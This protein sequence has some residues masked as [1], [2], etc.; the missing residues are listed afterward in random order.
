M[1]ELNIISK[2]NLYKKLKSIGLNQGLINKTLPKWWENDVLKTNA[3]ILEFCLVVK[4][5]LGLDVDIAESGDISFIPKVKNIEF[6][7]RANVEFEKLAPSSFLAQ[8]I[9]S[10]LVNILKLN[11]VAPP[12]IAKL[13][14][15]IKQLEDLN[16]DAVIQLF[17]QFGLP[18]IYVEKLAPNISKPAGMVIKN[19]DY[20]CILL[21]H[22]QKSPGAQLFVLLH[23]FGHIVSGHL[24]NKDIVVDVSMIELSGTLLAEYDEQETEADN[25]S[26]S[27]L[28]REQDIQE[29]FSKIPSRPS[30]A[31]LAAIAMQ[32]GKPLGISVSHLALSY[33]KET[34]D[35]VAT[36]NAL[37]FIERK[38]VAQDLIKQEFC[39]YINTVHVRA[40]DLSFLNVVQG[41]EEE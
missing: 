22:G 9:T 18:V 33:G 23:E 27:L 24:E 40:D 38:V 35:W 13:W 31:R 15:E 37:K 6:K 30:P 2:S 25:I 3:G 26:L 17:W 16:L 21:G 5:R 1:T 41:I 14:E 20:Y 19:G 29:F 8:G 7:K 12:N 10:T 36:Y 11:D 4:S 34:N 32:F 28:R 39:K